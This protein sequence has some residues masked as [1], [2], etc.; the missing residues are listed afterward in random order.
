MATLE[1]I[2]E[3]LY[4]LA[5]ASSGIPQRY[6]LDDGLR[7]D[8]LIHHGETQLQISRIEE[9]PSLDEYRDILDNWPVQV[10]WPEPTPAAHSGRRFLIA[11][12]LQ[13]TQEFT[14]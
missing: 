14:Q 11:G 6:T 3:D 9:F 4:K 8:V 1:I 13:P 10:D 7:V 5:R 12:W 2:L